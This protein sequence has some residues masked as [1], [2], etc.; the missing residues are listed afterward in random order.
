MVDVPGAKGE[1]EDPDDVEL[2]GVEAIRFRASAARANYL[3]L[4]RPTFSFRLKKYAGPCL[5]QDKAIG[6][7]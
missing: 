7:S 4:G 5:H 1:A 2:A 6:S 3:A